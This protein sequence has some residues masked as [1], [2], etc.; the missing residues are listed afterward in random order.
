MTTI[1]L[2]VFEK[3]EIEFVGPIHPPKKR[4]GSRYIIT[5]TEYLTIWGKSTIVK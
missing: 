5:T 3:W 1:I 2:Q 4:S